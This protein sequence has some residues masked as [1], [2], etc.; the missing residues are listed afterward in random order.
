MRYLRFDPGC[1]IIKITNETLPR[2][3]R[4]SVNANRSIIK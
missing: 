1:A 3:V 2:T 4:E